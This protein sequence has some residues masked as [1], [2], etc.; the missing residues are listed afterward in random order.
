LLCFSCA[1]CFEWFNIKKGSRFIRFP[2]D[3][4][5]LMSVF[6]KKFPWG[7]HV[8]K[9]VISPKT[10]QM[11][12]SDGAG[13]CYQNP[14]GN[15]G[16]SEPPTNPVVPHFPRTLDFRG[17]NSEKCGTGPEY[18]DDHRWERKRSYL[19]MVQRPRTGGDVV[20][21]MAGTARGVCGPPSGDFLG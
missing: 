8:F 7:N 9:K 11:L 19:A 6:I 17:H 4:P 14:A 20:R 13:F 16:T 12:S 2:C 18:T 5:G 10:C 3:L 21:D 15:S 1:D